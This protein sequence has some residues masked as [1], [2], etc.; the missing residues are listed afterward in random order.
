MAK[1][2]ASTEEEALAWLHKHLAS[3]RDVKSP[4]LFEEKP[5]PPPTAASHSA[6]VRS[7][8]DSRQGTKLSSTTLAGPATQLTASQS[9]SSRAKPEPKPEQTVLMFDNTPEGMRNAVNVAIKE[10]LIEAGNNAQIQKLMQ[11]LASTRNKKTKGDSE[12]ERSVGQG[13]AVLGKIKD[14]HAGEGEASGAQGTSST[15]A[16]TVQGDETHALG[17]TDDGAAPTQTSKD[18]DRA[19]AQDDGQ[20]QPVKSQR[21]KGKARKQAKQAAKK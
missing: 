9:S 2:Y 7:K 15:A 21:L 16:T 11:L 20:T 18:V 13:G 1:F 3:S 5:T 10:G 19:D 17:T 14:E 4:S 6:G 8:D 12:I